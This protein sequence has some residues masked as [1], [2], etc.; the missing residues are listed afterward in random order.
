M[1]LLRAFKAENIHSFEIKDLRSK[2]SFSN[3]TENPRKAYIAA[4]LGGILQASLS[5]NNIIGGAHFAVYVLAFINPYANRWGAHF[6]FL[7]GLAFS[8]WIYIGSQDGSGL[9]FFRS[10]Y[11]RGETVL[12]GSKTYRA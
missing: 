1:V 7:F 2:F 4:N 8:T 9:N 6:G 11:L 3:R 12:S 10:K 5:I